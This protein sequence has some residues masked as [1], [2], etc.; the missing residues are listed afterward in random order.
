V[1]EKSVLLNT[2]AYAHQFEQTG[3]NYLPY[4]VLSTFTF[5]DNHDHAHRSHSHVSSSNRSRVLNTHPFGIIAHMTDCVLT[6]YSYFITAETTAT[7][8][9]TTRIT[10]TKTPATTT[11]KP[12]ESN[13]PTSHN[14]LLAF[15][16]IS[17]TRFNNPWV[18]RTKL[19]DVGI[20]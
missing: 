20:L 8:T 6:S 17:L 11:T 19:A 15:E 1:S 5:R 14:D 3:L 7:T 18:N 10:K 4:E 12:G 13:D 2:W 9:R 16:L